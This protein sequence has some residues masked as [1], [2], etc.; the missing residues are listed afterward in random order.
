[1]PLN[2]SHDPLRSS[3]FNDGLERLFPPS[4]LPS[5]HRAWAHQLLESAHRSVAE[6]SLLE[7]ASDGVYPH[8]NTSASLKKLRVNLESKPQSSFKPTF[9]FRIPRAS[10][11]LADADPIRSAG[12]HDQG[13]TQLNVV[14]EWID[15]NIDAVDER[16]VHLR[17]LDDLARVMHSASDQHPDLHTVDCLG[18]TDDTKESRYGLIYK[19]PATSN[20]TLNQIIS[21]PD[22]KTPD[23]DERVRLAQTLAVALWSLHSLDWLHKS[24]CSN[25]ILFFPSPLSTG[26]RPVATVADISSPVLAGFDGSRPDL[27]TDMSLTSKKSPSSAESLHRHPGSLHPSRRRPYCKGYDIYSLGLVLLEI[28]LWKVLQT[29]HRPQYSAER[30][31]DKVVLAV[32]VPGLGSKVGRLYRGV[33]EKCLTV[34]ED[35]SSQEASQF[36]ESIVATLEGIRI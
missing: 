25:N 11:T 10:L 7:K 29:Y 4:R 20:C 30:W 27:D 17:R 21:S 16:F 2:T 3:D 8:L 12:F 36:M 1:M 23:L 33:V 22:L 28:G 31:R 34:D 5:I 13:G 14:V 18:Y 26:T 24:L 15:Y 9:A 6:L 19:A 35:I 32:L